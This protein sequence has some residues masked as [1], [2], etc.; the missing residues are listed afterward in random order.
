MSGQ[1]AFR[2][3]LLQ[4]LPGERGVAGPEGK[5]VSGLATRVANLGSEPLAGFIS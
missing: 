5:P 3:I 1:G 4:G 2:P